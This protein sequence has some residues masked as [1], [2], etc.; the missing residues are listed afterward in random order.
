MAQRSI[1]DFLPGTSAS[2]RTRVSH[3]EHKGSTTVRRKRG[4]DIDVNVIDV[5]YVD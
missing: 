4:T 3:V 1:Q 5:L 2:T